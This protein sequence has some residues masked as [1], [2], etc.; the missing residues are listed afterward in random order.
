MNFEQTPPL[1]VGAVLLDSAQTQVTAA[2]STQRIQPP[3]PQD[4]E[5]EVISGATR[6]TSQNDIMTLDRHFVRT[7]SLNTSGWTVFR[8]ATFF[9]H[10][11]AS[12]MADTEQDLVLLR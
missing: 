7:T 5:K 1:I 10:L 2:A 12:Q 8:K 11:P 9:R 3:V 4:G 6:S